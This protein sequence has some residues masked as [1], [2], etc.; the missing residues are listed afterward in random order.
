MKLTRIAGLSRALLAHVFA[1]ILFALTPASAHEVRPAVADVSVDAERVE[2]L[3]RLSAEGLLAGINLSEVEDTDEAPEAA[4]YDA[5]RLL[6]P[7]DLMA[8]FEAAW[9]SL[10]D[11]F[12]VNSDG[13]VAVE[14]MSVEIAPVGDPELPRDSAVLLSG[15][16][17]AGDAPVTFGWLAAYGPLVVRQGEG[18]NAYSAYLTNGAISAPLPREGVAQETAFETF[19]DYI[20]IGFEHIIPKG[21]DH[22][23]FVLG[24][25]FFSLAFRPL[26][27]QVTAFT[28]AHTVTLAMAS[29]GWVTV[30]GA[31]VEPLIAASITY[32]AVENIFRPKLGWWR[33]AVVFGFGLLHG[34][35]FASVLGDVG[36]DP[37]RFLT[38]L[39]AFNIGVEIGQLA[40]IAA[41][42]LLVGYWFGKKPWYRQR[43]AIPAS[44]AIALVGAYWFVE[45]VFF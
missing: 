29:L 17:P 12:Q 30:S 40:V 5:L 41:A 42:F 32:V 6:S 19:V 38:G 23:L 9:P 20:V 28:L 15:A 16:L 22:I 39:I 35:G 2:I 13:A 26:L 44:I 10:Q 31:I 27:W 14:L 36:L 33:T 4:E 7:E 8:R 3:V 24:L 21:L 45:R 25:F 34:L 11:G 1:I 43:I 18:E 37:T